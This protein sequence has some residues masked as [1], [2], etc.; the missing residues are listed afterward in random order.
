MLKTVLITLLG[1]T[2][3]VTVTVTL[4]QLTG[5]AASPKNKNEM[6]SALPQVEAWFA[7][8]VAPGWKT[9]ENTG[10]TLPTGQGKCE[11]RSG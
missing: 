6:L 8:G 11:G 2:V 4:L 10:N 3:T 1:D 7:C 5:S 9:E